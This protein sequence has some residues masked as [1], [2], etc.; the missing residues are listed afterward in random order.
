VTATST[1]READKTGTWSIEQDADI[2]RSFVDARS[3]ADFCQAWLALL[4]RQ[5]S[6]VR[7]GVVLFQSTE[8]N[9]FAPVAVWPDVTRDLAFLGSI[10]Q[11]ALT[12]AHGVI[13][14][15]DSAA[16]APVQVAYPIQIAERLL[17]AVVLEI[18]ARPDPE[19]H[20]L[21]RQLHWG[22]A[23]LHDLSRRREMAANE[24][25][26]ERIGTVME[27]LATALRPG[28]LQ[29]V[30][31]DVANHVAQHLRCSRVAIGLVEDD[32]ARVAALSNAAWFEKNANIVKLYAAAMEETYDRLA[33]FNHRG[34]TDPAGSEAGAE[35]NSAHGR[36]ARESGAQV[37]LSVPLL[38]GAD[39]IGIL[40]LE[41]N[42]DEPFDAEDNAWVEAL[43]SLLP[44]VI[45][46]K[47]RAERGYLTRLRED[48]RR[49]GTRL[50]GPKH[51]T[52]KFSAASLLLLLAVTVL[53]E[54]DYRVSA[55]MVI[56]GEIQRAAVAP[57]NGFVAE[58]HVRPGDIVKQDQLLATLDDSDLQLERHKWKSEYEQANR[59]LRDAMAKHDLAAYQVLSAQQQQAEAQLALAEDRIRRARVTAPFDGVV[60]SGDLSQ[61]IGSPIEQG[62]KLF[63]VAPLES[64]RVILQVDEHEIR[65]VQVGQTGRLVISGLADDPVPFSVSKV[66]PVATAEDGRNFF[67]V[68]ARLEQ[69]LPGLRPG[70]EGVGKIGTGER[71]LWWVLTHSFTDWLRLTLWTWLP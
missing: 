42:T 14:R 8:A 26:A 71:R 50:F 56:E 25:R 57:F 28:R 44:E 61:L 31:F 11:R 60:I 52:W 43:A 40:T 46:Q 5:L 10:A 51:L 15:P 19:V 3:D 27:T 36:L 39:C 64:Y 4:C 33:P 67:R 7:A 1:E 21:L 2:W 63:E 16:E 55:K 62:K 58:S 13:H 38:S 20:A 35:P 48:L 6:G 70:M 18:S 49:L 34:G 47:R 69:A 29:Q 37:I 54:I 53:A 32:K 65:H 23:W 59:K 22:I 17:G 41:R 68:E 9:T 12:E 30:L 45:D 24:A 66:T